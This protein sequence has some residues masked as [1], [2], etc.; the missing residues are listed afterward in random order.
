MN[1]PGWQGEVPPVTSA[2]ADIVKEVRIVSTL[3]SKTSK[4]PKRPKSEVCAPSSVYELVMAH[5][6]KRVK[7]PEGVP[8]GSFRGALS[9]HK[10][11]IVFD[12]YP[13]DLLMEKQADTLQQK[14]VEEICSE[15]FDVG[16]RPQFLRYFLFFSFARERMQ[17]YGWRGWFQSLCWER[18]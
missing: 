8:S 7:L 15:R 18:G 1:Q 17:D 12:S 14:L 16:I 13:N 2:E 10:M 3:S 5:D 11:A 4:T 6:S 9:A